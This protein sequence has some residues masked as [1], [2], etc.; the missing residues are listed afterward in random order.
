MTG[1]RIA[2]VGAG[3]GAEAW[4]TSLGADLVP[5]AAGMAGVA[6][7]GGLDLVIDAGAD[8]DA[9]A[10]SA[11]L[12]ALLAVL[13]GRVPV[14]VATRL[15]TLEAL[16]PGARYATR[17]VGL[18]RVSR[19]AGPTPVV[20]V[21]LPAAFDDAVVDAVL[22]LLGA[23]GL[24]ALPVG[25]GPGRIVDRLLA[26]WWCAAGGVAIAVGGR[27]LDALRAGEAAAVIAAIARDLGDAERFVVQAGAG[28]GGSAVRAGTDA[29]GAP[30]RDR[31][32]Q[33]ATG[34]AP[35]AAADLAELAV[36]AEAYRLVGEAAAGAAEIERAMTAGAGWDAGPF[37]LAGRRG[38]RA[39]VTQIA[40][41]GR[42]PDA[43]AATHDRFAMPPLLW[44]MATA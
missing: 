44:R 22:D 20:E 25:D 10:R 33:P 9:E 26:S 38:L 24:E 5:D 23:H 15:H 16:L 7:G 32:P 4:A 13:P 41:L 17:I 21:A 14:A 28:S 42:D 2:V 18:H 34:E 19:A 27:P 36:I 43:D 30:S 37:T 40:A 39:V 31:A 6:G 35:P 29:A 8:G 3:A 12:G 1:G 11:S